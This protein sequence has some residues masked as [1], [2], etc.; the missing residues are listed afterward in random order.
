MRLII[1]DEAYWLNKYLMWCANEN[2]TFILYNESIKTVDKFFAYRVFPDLVT[3]YT[4]NKEAD[5]ILLINVNIKIAYGGRQ[6]QAGID[7]LKHI[8]YTCLDDKFSEFI[9]F[10][11]VVLYS[12]ESDWELLQRKPGS[13]IIH[14]PNV[15]FLRLPEGFSNFEDPA[16]FDLILSRKV[17]CNPKNLLPFL[18]SD[19]PDGVSLYDHS[20][21][22]LAGAPKLI[23]EFTDEQVVPDSDSIFENYNNLRKKDLAFKQ[24][25]QMHDSLV[26]GARPIP[27]EWKFFRKQTQQMRVLYIDDQ[28]KEGWSFALYT[29]LRGRQ[30][31]EN[32]FDH[33]FIVTHSFIS[34][35]NLLTN[36]IDRF[37]KELNISKS[38]NLLLEKAKE[39]YN[40][41]QHALVNLNSEISQA[42]QAKNIIEKQLLAAETTLNNCKSTLITS[43]QS[44]LDSYI[45]LD[46]ELAGKTHQKLD[47]LKQVGQRMENFNPVLDKYFHARKQFEEKFNELAE[48]EK[49][50]LSLQNS[51]EILKDEFNKSQKE[52]NHCKNLSVANQNVINNYPGFDII[53]LDLRLDPI[54]DSNCPVEKSSGFLL[55]K[56]INSFC[57]II[58]VIVMTA[59]Q[60][61]STLKAVSGA[62][63]DSYWIKGRETGI[64]LRALIEVAIKKK[65]LIDEWRK[66]QLIIGKDKLKCKKATGVV[67]TNSGRF[68]VIYNDVELAQGNYDR[69]AIENSLELCLK[70]FSKYEDEIANRD[71]IIGQIVVYLALIQELRFKDGNKQ[72]S[73]P[74]ESQ[75]V[76]WVNGICQG[77]DREVDFKVTRNKFIHERIIPDRE[78]LLDYFKYIV[79]VLLK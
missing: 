73:P 36:N 31:I 9:R 64:E 1:I 49:N 42:I 77:K 6:S 4:N 13:L 34:T 2:K 10:A 7:I 28:H 11:P 54:K 24:I 25:G 22:N 39:T 51:L 21:R 59:S 48:A 78:F 74:P 56:E 15:T 20:Y 52:L 62:G 19:I 26:P 43:M 12:L 50:L 63:Y 40:I 5:L 66:L 75:F 55:L 44:V 70:W 61:A 53:F 23:Q 67:Q 16:F 45:A 27:D 33:N 30:P 18:Y 41:K 69:N 60:K 46:D 72:K 29:G 58:P 35:K 71:G 68:N 57:P 17:P 76:N 38:I 3:V 47:E 8:R 79:E 37:N 32:R 14:S 65:P